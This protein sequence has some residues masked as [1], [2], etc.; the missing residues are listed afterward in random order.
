MA[1]ELNYKFGIQL[2]KNDF[3]RLQLVCICPSSWYG[4]G[5]NCTLMLFLW[6]EPPLVMSLV[7]F[8][9]G[10]LKLWKSLFICRVIDRTH[11]CI[12]FCTYWK[13]MYLKRNNILFSMKQTVACFVWII[14]PIGVTVMI[15]LTLSFD[16]HCNLC[17]LPK[18]G[19]QSLKCCRCTVGY[20]NL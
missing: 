16:W 13:N 9:W 2:V 7:E 12:C 14:N 6:S 20:F 8:S 5:C 15:N 1:D 17:L 19:A 10:C 11:N 3:E 4:S 18:A